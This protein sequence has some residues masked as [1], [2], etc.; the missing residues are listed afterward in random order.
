MKRESQGLQIAVILF[1]M[2][3]VVMAGTAF[4]FYRTADGAVKKMVDAEKSK[5]TL[6]NS[7]QIADFKAQYLMHILGAKPLGEALNEVEAALAGDADI[8]EVKTAYEQHMATYGEP[9]QAGQPPIATYRDLLPNLLMALRGKNTS[10]SSL[11]QQVDLLNQDKTRITEEQKKRTDEAQQGMVQ[12]QNDLADERSK[13]NEERTRV[14]SERTN[15]FAKYKKEM[16]V[17]V[18]KLE[19]AKQV[20]TQRQ[21][22]LKKLG[23]VVTDQ[24][25]RIEELRD[26]PFEVADG[27]ITWVN[28]E[29]G[30]VWIN[31][32]LG[33]GLRRQTLF[34]VYDIE[35]N[36]VTRAERKASIE[37]TK[38]LD[39]HLAEARIVSDVP[40]DPILPGDQVFSPAWRP[41][42]KVR[43]ALAGFL[44]VDGDRKSDREMIRSL[45][46]ASGAAIDAEVHDDGTVEGELTASTRYLVRGDRPTDTSDSKVLAAFTSITQQAQQLGVETIQLDKLLSWMGYK[47]EARTV[48]LGESADPLQFKA[49]AEG[50]KA[51]TSTGNV[52]GKFRERTPPSPAKKDSAY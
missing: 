1:A 34:S 38:V 42:R 12:A 16:Q 46:M 43:F 41:G 44:D 21:T 23:D 24:K 49:E 10:T 30:T 36:G 14:T 17:Y 50:G 32:G 29:A 5:K 20:E 8:Q 33:D 26:E 37:V 27:R 28:Q 31:L 52:S 7:F 4:F 47:L 35:D 51:R 39:Q 15:E 3:T 40:S 45:L 6:Q 48:G 19:Q 18:T 9:A 11:S 25:R 22:E 2:L 13:F